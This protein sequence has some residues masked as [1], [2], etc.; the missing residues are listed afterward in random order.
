MLDA[1]ERQLCKREQTAH[2][3]AN[4]GPLVIRCPM[5]RNIRNKSHIHKYIMYNNQQPSDPKEVAKAFNSCFSSII[6]TDI[7]TN[8]TTP[9]RLTD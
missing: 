4:P 3:Q 5:C 9:P 1:F 7:A 2:R 8:L 6:T